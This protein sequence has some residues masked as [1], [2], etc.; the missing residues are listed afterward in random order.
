MPPA[1]SASALQPA[2]TGVGSYYPGSAPMEAFTTAP[3]QAFPTAPPT[4]HVVGGFVGELGYWDSLGLQ[5]GLPLG[6]QDRD[7]EG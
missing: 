7:M 6:M 3:M 2:G 4:G 1:S 5:N